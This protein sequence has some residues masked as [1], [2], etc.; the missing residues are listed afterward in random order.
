MDE[1]VGQ[2]HAHRGD[3]VF[4]ARLHP[5]IQELRELA[6]RGEAGLTARDAEVLS[7]STVES[8][9]E[10]IQTKLRGATRSATSSILTS[11]MGD[12]PARLL[13]LA[14]LSSGLVACTDATVRP[15]TAAPSLPAQ[16]ALAAQPQPTPPASP[17]IAPPAA[18]APGTD[19][20]V[21]MFKNKS[22]QE[23]AGELEK[24]FD[25]GVPTP[26]SRPR[27]NPNANK[28]RYKGVDFT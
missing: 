13:C 2:L 19:P 27:P 18:A 9:V 26:N 16:E 7:R 5:F 25:A 12:R 22:P 8:L 17:P 23:V 20:L 24:A 1:L 14:L 28:P 4:F 3:E 11:I 6:A 10:E 21:E 15:T